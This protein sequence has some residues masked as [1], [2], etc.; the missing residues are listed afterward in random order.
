MS[1]VT[2]EN[3]VIASA[4]YISARDH[5]FGQVFLKEL[6]IKMSELTSK[7]INGAAAL[8]TNSREGIIP[9]FMDASVLKNDLFFMFMFAAGANGKRRTVAFI[10][11]DFTSKTVSDFSKNIV[12]G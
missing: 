4:D 2:I 12:Y 9:G 1:L 5:E 8:F 11:V 7:G 3:D 10:V 6:V